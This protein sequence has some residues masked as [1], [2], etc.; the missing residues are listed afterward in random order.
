MP[1]T[2]NMR[3][4]SLALHPTPDHAPSTG[5]KRTAS[6]RAIRT[7]TTRPS[8]YYA[9][10]YNNVNGV[11]ETDDN[12]VS[13][14][15]FFPALQYYSDAITTLP[16]EVMRQFTLMKE[17]DAKLHGPNERFRQMVDELLAMPPLAHT[18]LA[19]SNTASSSGGGGGLLSFTASNSV[20][21]SASASLINGVAG[22][23]VSAMHSIAG[24]QIGEEDNEEELAR[25]RKYHE[26]KL[27]THSMLPNLDEKNVVLA[28][29]SRV[30]ALQLSRIDSVTP[31]IDNEISEEARL[32]SMTHWAY[33]E[34]R[35]KKAQIVNAP[36]RRD[37]AAT[38]NLAAAAHV[39]HETEIAQA[40]R[41]AGK[42]AQKEK[43]KG[44]RGHA[45][46]HVDSEFEERPKKMGM[47]GGKAKVASQSLGATAEP[48]KRRKVDKTMLAPGMERMASQTSARGS[49]ATRE[50]PRS[51]PIAEAGKKVMKAKPVPAIPKRKV[52]NSA[53]NSP[54]LASSP[55][56][57]S[58]NPSNMEP[59][60]S[61]KSQ[62]ARLRNNST[63]NLRHER[64]VDSE[65][66]RPS[67][68]AG[69]LNHNGEKP[70]G[71]RKAPHDEEQ[72][73]ASERAHAARTT[74]SND[75]LKREDVEMLDAETQPTPS[76]STSAKN[77]TRISKPGTPRTGENGAAPDATT[78]LR[79]RSTRSQRRGGAITAGGAEDSGSETPSQ[80]HDEA[81]GSFTSGGVGGGGVS[82]R[83]L[84]HRRN[85]SN[86]HLIKQLA[87]F[88]RSPD[89]DRHRGSGEE[90]SGEGDGESGD[91]GE[92][93]RE[94][95]R[96]Q[97]RLV[98][99]VG[100]GIVSGEE[101]VGAGGSG[102]GSTN[103]SG[104][105][106]ALRGRGSRPI[107]RRNTQTSRPVLSPVA[108]VGS[109]E[110]HNES[111]TRGQTMQ[112]VE[113]VRGMVEAASSPPRDDEDVPEEAPEL[114]SDHAGDLSPDEEEISPAP[115]MLE[116]RVELP[117]EVEEAGDEMEQ[118]L[119]ADAT[120]SD[121]EPDEVQPAQ[122]LNNHAS[123]HAS[124]DGD[125]DSQADSVPE[126]D[127]LVSDIASDIASDM[128]SDVDE[129]E[130]PDD[131][132]EPK[133][134]YCDRGSYGEMVACDNPKCLR[135]WF[136]LGCTE[137]REA[138]EEEVKWFCRDC[139]PR[140]FGVG[141]GMAAG[142]GGG[143]GGRGGRG[144]GGGARGR[145]MG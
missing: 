1:P 103:E 32:G 8:N 80:Y 136:H 30:L 70:Y 82:G 90:S 64:L 133:Y 47:K 98:E 58:F 113:G 45:V 115:E 56:H 53:M 88:N 117:A 120:L 83:K 94:Q 95:R 15:G 106:G 79:T 65:T 34:N 39:L 11:P 77:S 4:T 42:E 89:L 52:T 38:N 29:T 73:Q 50:T 61:G 97:R 31:H 26:L 59:P 67:S 85:A 19:G 33:S 68:A 142:V 86:S 12:Y 124:S 121:L 110:P 49:K 6:G 123:G 140:G 137:L 139:R 122:D 99:G 132:N 105:G 101:G 22:G 63:T 102:S 66:S 104:H 74:E 127:N 92:E 116:R 87:P 126:E 72:R 130:D 76:R 57:T 91:G 18:G 10:P 71:K 36:V 27:L 145:Q 108:I 21:G 24:S 69:K 93:R 44:K 109:P 118:E 60:P 7:N 107:S 143:R 112:H 84:E 16:K 78:M 128:A 100:L 14:P 54:A 2:S 96:S 43:T 62:G 20:V 114:L 134:C 75:D 13:E 141:N 111:D 5:S 35:Q 41:D 131:P 81:A 119:D 17:V 125:N 28:Q 3:K 55:L 37:I 25:R 144:R 40:R 48:V 9:R 129:D 23:N 46:E 135:E 51:T 138:P